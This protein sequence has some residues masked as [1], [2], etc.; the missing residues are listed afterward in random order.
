MELMPVVPRRRP[1]A[2]F[3]LAAFA[4]VAT[5][6]ISTTL[7]GAAEPLILNTPAGQVLA[8]FLDIMATGDEGKART[9]IT[10]RYTDD[11]LAA[12]PVESR[13][14]GWKNLMADLAR[15]RL[16][17]VAMT[18][19]RPGLVIESGASGEVF[20]V[21][22]Q[23]QPEAPF[24]IMGILMQPTIPG[25]PQIPEGP[26]TDATRADL[27]NQ[28]IDR[29]VADDRFSGVVLLAKDGKTVYERATGM[30]SKSYG[31]PNRI[32]TKFCLGSMNKMFT[33]LA[34]ARLVQDGKLSYQD[35]LGRYLPDFP[36]VDV[37]D[38][39]TIHQL[40]THTSGLGSYFDDPE[41]AAG[42]TGMRHVS[43]YLPAVANEK[44][45]FE[46]GAEMSY[47]NS[48]YI[49]LGLIIEKVSGQDYY[50][51]VRANVFVPAG[52]TASDS[53]END[54]VVPNLAT[55]YT[56][57]SDHGA[58][59]SA[60]RRANFYEHSVRGTPAGGG[61]ST[62]PDLLK[63]ERA[64]RNGTIVSKALVDTVTTAKVPMGP[65]VGYGYGFGDFRGRGEGYY[66]HNG[67]APGMST[68]FR[69]YDTLGYTVIVLSNYDGVAAAVADFIDELILP[70]P[71]PQASPPRPGKP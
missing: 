51:F 41:Y 57:H 67:G 19:G 4:L 23:Q 15:P 20:Q 14:E 55:G 33:S 56:R 36:N 52:M 25:K 66:G 26:L 42:W 54:A 49:V 60:T 64:L 43:D 47:S 11:A 8:E 53:Y 31:A 44:L 38:K 2:G 9:F 21:V 48:G 59:D 45:A 22:L 39:V 5:L 62:A 28:L 27:I 68:D 37:R 40:L 24:K 65:G 6:A 10:N 18:P 3:T 70:P 16:L 17:E 1:L 29:L 34:I 61:Y 63:F 7:A 12:R 30:A 50:D 13:L 46:P 58:P 35:K 69:I 32:D 71:S